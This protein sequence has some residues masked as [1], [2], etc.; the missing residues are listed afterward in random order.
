MSIL[1]AGPVAIAAAI[2]RKEASSEEITR[3]FLARIEAQ[4]SLGAFVE[5]RPE[6]AIADARRKDAA[7]GQADLPPFH[8]VPIGVKDLNFVRF[9]RTRLGTR[10]LPPIWSPMDDVTVGRLREAGFVFLGKTATSELGAMPVTEPDGQPAARN[11]WDPARTPGGSSGGSAAAVAAGLLPVAHGSDGGGSIRIPA[12]FCGLVGLKATRGRIPNAFGSRDPEVI[13][14]CGALTRGVADASALFEVMARTRVSLEPPAPLRIRL[15][16]ES[17][18]GTTDPGVRQRVEELATLLEAMGH[19]I[20][21]VST[22]AI[23]LEEF[24]PVWQTLFTRLRFVR[25]DRTQPVTRWLVAGGRALPPGLA[26]ERQ[27]DITRRVLAWQEGADVLLTP[28]VPVPPPLVGAYADLDGEAAFRA[29]AVLGS[30][31]AAFNVTGQPAISVPAG[32]HPTL[33]LPVGAQ[34][35]GA[36]GTDE[37]LLALA[38]AI[39]AAR[40]APRFPEPAAQ[41]GVA[42]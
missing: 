40:P 20:E 16:L 13:Y 7:R 30:F 11:P 31:T 37:R 35:V 15:A 27:R 34:L 36:M 24:L 1:D 2:R 14:T 9:W 6:R 3:A 42:G 8:G 25:W 17:P 26:L 32:L 23:S 22:T 41:P 39:E 10:G 21:A 33:G 4:A 28:T 29:S 38:Q 5:V 12:S 18:L 19:S